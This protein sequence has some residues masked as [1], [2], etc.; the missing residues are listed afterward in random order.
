M[1]SVVVPFRN[2]H[3]TIGRLLSSLPASVPVI[4]VDDQSKPA[5]KAK[6]P[7]VRVIRPAARGYFSGAVN[8]GIG[9]CATDV[10]VINQDVHFPTGLPTKQIERLARDFAFFGDGVMGHKAWP[11]GYVQGTFMY[12]RRDAIDRIGGLDAEHYPL[13]GATCEWQLR[14]CRAGFRAKPL[15]APEWIAHARGRK[16]FGSSIAA[17]LR[18]EPR[19]KRLFIRTP[20][21]ISVVISCYNY[22][23][24]LKDAVASLVGGRSCLGDMAPQT[25]GSFEVVIVDDA[26]TDGTEKVGRKLASPWKGIR[27]IRRSE[28]GGTPVA[29]NTGIAASFGKVIAILCA[30]DMMESWRL[31]AMYDALRSSGPRSFVY[32]DCRL[33]TNDERRKAWIM[34][35]WDLCA[36]AEK[37]AVHAGIMFP[38]Q[39]WHDAGGYSDAMRWG[40][41]DWEFNVS[42]GKAGWTG[43]H[44]R[45]PG[46]LYRRDGQGR[47]ERNTTAEWR[48]R[49]QAQMRA[50][51]PEVYAMCLSCGGSP[52]K[53]SRG[54]RTK[55]VT[56]D[57]SARAFAGESGMTLVQYIGKNAGTSTFWGPVTFVPYVFGGARPVGNVDDRDLRT[58]NPKNPG[59]L[60]QKENGIVCFQKYASKKK[61]RIAPAIAQAI[62]MD[63]EPEIPAELDDDVDPVELLERGEVGQVSR[64]TTA[65]PDASGLA[66]LLKSGGDL[67]ELAAVQGLSEKATDALA[68]AGYTTYVDLARATNEQLDAVPGIGKATIAKIRC[69]INTLLVIK[70]MTEAEQK[71]IQI[72]GVA[73]L[74]IWGE[75][76]N[77]IVSEMSGV[78]LDRIRELRDQAGV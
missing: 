1:F 7:R 37:N 66:A 48:S 76:G 53:A 65:G 61:Q 29:N 68:G 46:Y 20:P 31:G 43:I 50:I 69:Q 35:D 57:L 4:V 52:S 62:G 60:Q 70:G 54:S 67:R 45:R 26:S 6:D 39:A 25:F 47:T 24:Y 32:D 41:E 36:I 17:A 71:A 59:I 23:R 51:H 77:A 27:Y 12:M 13:W 33:V 42:L 63:V 55:R 44:V 34:G 28:T 10:L 5:Y 22:G 30:D 11:R 15:D 3:K 58:K 49:F 56:V 21:M 72:S 18:D 14:A 19:K 16:P 2:G 74:A 8:T 64:E 73:T 75:L 9:A 40:R 78:D 38:K